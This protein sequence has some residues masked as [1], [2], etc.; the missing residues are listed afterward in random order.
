MYLHFFPL[1]I[2]L[3]GYLSVV[4]SF[5]LTAKIHQ[6]WNSV[7]GALGGGVKH[8]R[9]REGLGYSK[10]TTVLTSTELLHCR[11]LHVASLNTN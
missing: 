7:A 10:M 4:E 8:P 9:K 6:N 5:P 1:L 11:L 3:D 2:W